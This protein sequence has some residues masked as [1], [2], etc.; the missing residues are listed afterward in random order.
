MNLTVFRKKGCVQK[1]FCSLLI[2]CNVA[3]VF[4]VLIA[5]LA[6]VKH[7]VPNPRRFNLCRLRPARSKETS[8]RLRQKII[9]THEAVKFNDN[10]NPVVASDNARPNGEARQLGLNA[11]S[12][13]FI[14]GLRKQVTPE[15]FQLASLRVFHDERAPFPAW[16]GWLDLDGKHIATYAVSDEEGEVYDDPIE[17]IG[18]AQEGFLSLNGMALCD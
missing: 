14:S 3:G 11:L 17:F 7:R 15:Q 18:L 8:S 4:A 10:V 12:G 16:Y 1:T 13:D 9:P 2:R 6:G 5:L